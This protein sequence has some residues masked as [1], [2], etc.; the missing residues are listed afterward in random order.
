MANLDLVRRL[1]AIL[2]ARFPDSP[3]APHADLIRFVEDRPGHDRRYAMDTTKINRE[4][5]WAPKESLE[6][7]LEKTV[8]WY[9]DH[10]DWL[11]AIVQEKGLEAWWAA[12]YAGR[13]AEG[14]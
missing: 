2:D 8:D 6:T 1:C 13:L 14:R 12:N 5:G 3:H 11:D 4:L 7:G 9:L 10:A